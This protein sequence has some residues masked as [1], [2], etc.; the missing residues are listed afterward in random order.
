M[1]MKTM[2]TRIFAV[3]S[4][5]AGALTF[6][7]AQAELINLR[8]D[9]TT[10]KTNAGDITMVHTVIPMNNAHDVEMLG[11]LK[12]NANGPATHIPFDFDGDYEPLLSMRTGADCMISS[13]RAWLDG[14]RLRVVYAQ[15]KG[16]WTAKKPV[17]FQ[18]F[19]LAV[20]D[21]GAPGTPPFYFVLRKKV[22]TKK[23]Y[24]DVKDALDKENGLYAGGV[25]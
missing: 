24:C 25:K 12:R 6:G 16:E 1:K 5:L 2:T 20:N 3:A 7:N 18:V 23:A 8:A 9:L 10:I 19:E 15:R 13:A 21:E 4:A 14:D 22:D 11:F 17:T